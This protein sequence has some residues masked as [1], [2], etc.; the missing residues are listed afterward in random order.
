MAPAPPPLDRGAAE[1][2]VNQ[3]VAPQPTITLAG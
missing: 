3:G 1:P 2:L